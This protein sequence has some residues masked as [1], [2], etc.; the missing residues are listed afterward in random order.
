LCLYLIRFNI[1]VGV[2]LMEK[3]KTAILVGALVLIAAGVAV[4]YFF[5]TPSQPGEII[6]SVITEESSIAEDMETGE[7]VEPLDVELNMSDAVVREL[8][9][10]LSSHPTLARL[11]MTDYLIRRFVTTVDLIV[12]GDSPRRPMDFIEITEDFQVLESE[13]QTYLDP[14]GYE[15]YNQT[16]GVIASLDA[17][18]SA[19]LYK[20][21][22]LPINQAYRDMGYPNEDFDATLKKAIFDL[23]ETPVIE[24]RI[25]LEKDVV[26]YL[27]VNS[28]LEELSAAQ[29][30]LLRMG[31]DNIL[32]IQAKLREIAGYLGFS[33]QP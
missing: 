26:T 20:Q 14:V 24:D 6:D 25:Y 8:A 12:K 15:R 3:H 29:K 30:H 17:K 21:L 7:V 31:P 18:G 22:K 4:Y 11:L 10:E 5:F 16:A 9:A 32:T 13:G 33:P 2:K 1:Q 28:E 23:L 19:V 27:F